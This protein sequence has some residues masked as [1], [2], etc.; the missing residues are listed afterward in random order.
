HGSR[1]VAVQQFHGVLACLDRVDDLDHA[2][3][4]SADADVV[5]YQI[6]R[7]PGTVGQFM[8]L[9]V[10]DQLPE[11]NAD[12]HGG[13]EVADRDS[14]DEPGPVYAAWQ[15]RAHQHCD[16]R[17]VCPGVIDELADPLGLKVLC[18]LAFPYDR[19]AFEPA[20]PHDLHDIGAFL[21]TLD[22]A[23]VVLGIPGT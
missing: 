3:G 6:R 9:R 17:T 7:P 4:E 8:A 20:F 1:H 23:D 22:H 14:V 16:S 13:V 21:A 19:P 5:V 12:V 11:R 10:H 15:H 18:P 2:G